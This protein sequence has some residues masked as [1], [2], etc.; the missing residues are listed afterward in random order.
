MFPVRLGG[1]RQRNNLLRRR[2]RNPAESRLRVRAILQ[3]FAIHSTT[4]MKS[5]RFA[6][7]LSVRL[8]AL[9]W[10]VLPLL[11]TSC[12]QSGGFIITLPVHIRVFNALVDGGQVTVSIGNTTV[13]SG[14]PFEGLTTYQEVEAGNQEIK[15]TVGSGSTIVDMTALFIDNAK[16]TYLIYGTSAAPTAL[17]LPDGAATPNGGE[18]TLI[19]PN[20]AFGSGGL[21]FYVTTPGASLDN[22]SPNL[23]N[24]QYS[25]VTSF[26][27]FTAG[28]YQVRATLPNSKQVIYD[29]G[30]QT[31]S[32][33]TAYYFVFYTKASA[34]LVNAALLAQDDSGSGSVINSKLAQF[35]VVHA[36][37]GTDP[38]VAQYDGTQAFS[39]IPYANAS[40]YGVLPN[41]THTITFETTTAPGALIAS[42]QRSFD[43]ATDTSVVVTGLLG[44]QSAF[45]LSDNNLPGTS[46]TARLRVVNAAPD[47]GPV[48]VLVNFARKIS[49]LQQ[50]TAS[51][52]SEFV[53]DTYQ[54]DFVM[55]GSAASLL[56]LPSV[57][58]TA[59]HTYTLYLTG[60]TG[61]FTGILTR[62]D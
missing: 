55:S 1:A 42:L 44:A 21:D 61:Q 6:R 50:N 39:G 7:S 4:N 40:S 54:I 16:Y 8:I 46:G 28:S 45:G 56:T 13:A 57:S 53:E 22:M 59:A 20:A 14:L 26:A 32:E 2:R 27:T 62:D 51:S 36:A 31:F 47:L 30:T 3:D 49:S 18:F 17:L 25:Q 33:K 15:V 29:G 9:A 38:L 5:V 19:V 34:T 23:S 58:L 43:P 48:D 60:T 35:K 12:L 11:L 10:M 37:P 52:Y 41:G 24:I